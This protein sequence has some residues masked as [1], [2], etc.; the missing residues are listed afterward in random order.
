[1]EKNTGMAVSARGTSGGLATLCSEDNFLLKTSFVTHHCIFIELQQVSSKISISLF[2]LYVP[3]NYLEKKICWKTLS[4]YMEI[5]SLTNIIVV[6]DL[7]IILDPKEK[8]GGN[9][10]KDPF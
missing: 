3:V 10:G 7:N 9:R 1:M 2:N 4:K 5:H 8:R 6:G